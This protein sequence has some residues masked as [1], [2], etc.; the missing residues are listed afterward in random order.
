MSMAKNIGQFDCMICGM[1]ANVSSR[2]EDRLVA[3]IVFLL[4]SL[5]LFASVLG[6]AVRFSS[7]EKLRYAAEDNRG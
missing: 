7:Q 2:G 4:P 3:L 1:G 6:V 5:L